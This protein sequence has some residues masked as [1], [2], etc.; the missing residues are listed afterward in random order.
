M[1]RLRLQTVKVKIFNSQNTKVQIV[2]E[3][4]NSQH[5]KVWLVLVN[6]RIKESRL[7]VN[8]QNTKV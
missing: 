3:L 5:T 2:H 4:L 1:S 6:S 7:Y 8:S